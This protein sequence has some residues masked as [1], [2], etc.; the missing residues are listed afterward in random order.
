MLLDDIKW[1]KETAIASAKWMA[2]FSFPEFEQDCEYVCMH[3]A[4]EYAVIEGRLVSNKGM[5]IPIR[6][7]DNHMIE[8]HVP[9]STAL[10]THV[11]GR[12]ICQ[13]GPMARYNLNYHQL[14]PIAKELAK[15][16]GLGPECSNPFRS[17]LVRI[18]EVIFAFDEAEQIIENYEE[19]DKPA[20]DVEPRAGTGYGCTEAPRGICYHRYT[21]DDNGIIKDAKIVSPTALNQPAIE[22]DLWGFVQNNIDLPDDKLQYRCEQ[23]IRNYD[24]CISCSTHFLDLRIDRE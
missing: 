4:D 7:Y 3:H 9:H 1:G 22:K 16:V 21:I 6:D 23:A 19:P 14:P 12:G 24:P 8:D 10:H 20:V 2:N 5:D 18:I 17:I 11:K 15:E 13:A